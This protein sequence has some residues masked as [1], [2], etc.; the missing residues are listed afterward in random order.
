M[1]PLAQGTYHP[2]RRTMLFVD[3]GYIYGVMRSYYS[4]GSIDELVVQHHKLAEYLRNRAEQ[5]LECTVL[6]IHWYDATDPTHRIPNPRAAAMS[7]VPGVRLREGNTVMVNGITKQKGVDTRLVADM[8]SIAFRNQ[9]TDF[10]VLS[11][12]DDLSPGVEEA[13]DLGVTVQ[14]WSIGGQDLPTSVSRNLLTLADRHDEIPVAELAEII[15]KRAPIPDLTGL[16]PGSQNGVGESVGAVPGS[17]AV[18]AELGAAEESVPAVDDSA[19]VVPAVDGVGPVRPRAP[20]AEPVEPAT[21]D[22]GHGVPTP[23][24]LAAHA[25]P[26]I[27][28]PRPPKPLRARKPQWDWEGEHEQLAPLYDLDF[29]GYHQPPA[30]AE[31]TTELQRA[32]ESGRVYAHRWW[33]VASEPARVYLGGLCPGPGHFEPIPAELDKDVLR[34]AEENHIDTWGPNQV[35]IEVR[36]GFWDGIDELAPADGEGLA[37]VS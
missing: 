23:A 13:Q 30:W 34:F 11:G 5:S 4:R 1:T 25:R 8:L 16:V 15:T 35:K 9:V 19:V 28:T 33:V 32:R 17:A 36:N 21:A 37:S 14:V 2:N 22:S 3:A 6:R 31:G 7:R 10:I 27:P 12:D 24:D 26:G 29:N 20:L 18:V